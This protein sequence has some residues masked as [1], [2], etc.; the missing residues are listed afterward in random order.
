M[1]AFIIIF[2][3]NPLGGNQIEWR[4]DCGRMLGQDY[5]PM[6]SI[7]VLTEAE[8]LTITVMS[9]HQKQNSGEITS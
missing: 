3:F 4:L 2:I 5:G 8:T 9:K 1:T 7:P 6:L